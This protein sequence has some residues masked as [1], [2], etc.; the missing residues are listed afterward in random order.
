LCFS[1]GVS[2]D[3]K[4]EIDEPS[5]E[6]L[7]HLCSVFI[8]LRLHSFCRNQKTLLYYLY[9]IKYKAQHKPILCR[10]MAAPLKEFNKIIIKTCFSVF[11][12]RPQ[13]QDIKSITSIN[14]YI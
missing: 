11:Q 13:T 10:S 14:I 2:I 8:Y 9:I 6:K 3:V 4:P 1:A 7:F 5:E 12:Q